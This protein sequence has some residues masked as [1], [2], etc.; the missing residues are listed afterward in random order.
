MGPMLRR[1]L[2]YRLLRGPHGPALLQAV[3]SDPRIRQVRRAIDWIRSH[4]A[5]TV[6]V[7]E[8]A[9]CAG[10]AEAT[11]RRHFRVAT[12]MSPVQFQKILRLQAAR[13]LLLSGRDVIRTAHA[14]GYESASQ[15]SR[16]YSRTF[17]R[18]P[19]QEARQLQPRAQAEGTA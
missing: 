13:R 6:P 8:L 19:S 17:G 18:P 4:V 7:A 3:A 12:G 5:E 1:E 14:V 10:M 11:F 15:F 2:L 16:D 9:S